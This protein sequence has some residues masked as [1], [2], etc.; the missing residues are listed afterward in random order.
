LEERE[1]GEQKRRIRKGAGREPGED[2]KKKKFKE[3]VWVTIKPP[4]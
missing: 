3:I 2:V 4:K 1:D